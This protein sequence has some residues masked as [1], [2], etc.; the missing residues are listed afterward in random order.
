MTYIR[1]LVWGPFSLKRALVWSAV[2]VTVKVAVFSVAYALLSESDVPFGMCFWDCGYYKEISEQ[3]YTQFRNSNSNLAFFPLFPLGVRYLRMMVPDFDFATVAIALNII[4]FGGLTFLLSWWSHEV[5]FKTYYYLPGLL[6]TVDRFSL[7]SHV[8]YTESL[9]GLLI[10]AACL[11]R[12]KKWFGPYNEWVVA[13]IGGL[14]SGVRIVGV[15]IVAGLGL[16][17]IKSYFKNPLKGFGLLVLG[18]SGV[19]LFFTYLH[20]SQGMWDASLKT[21]ATWGR[22]FSILGLFKSI[23]FFIKYFY[24]PTIIIFLGAV[25]FLCRPPKELIFSLQ[26]RITFAMLLV[27]PMASTVQ[28]S[29][30]RY[31]TVVFIGYMSWAWV[32]LKFKNKYALTL[33]ALVLC[34]ELYWQ[35]ALSMKFF[36]GLVFLWAG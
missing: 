24:F 6:L 2:F 7:W 15:S 31:V 30:T 3:G 34:M 19:A 29:L 28:T 11:V 17:N 5:G 23:W 20:F 8:P 25:W 21:T 26:E 14:A 32:V 4:L 16:A 35:V 36:R 12:K 22:H 27:I 18:L 10:L 1:N 33:W 13:L 9:F